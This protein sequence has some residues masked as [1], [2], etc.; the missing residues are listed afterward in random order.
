MFKKI[1]LIVS[2]LTL[3]VLLGISLYASKDELINPT[4][5]IAHEW[6]TFT[7]V[8]GP[9]GK[10]ADWLPLSG[11]SDLPCFVDYFETRLFKGLGGPVAAQPTPAQLAIT[12][13]S[14]SS[15]LAA[16][17]QL[18]GPIRME[19]PVIYFYSPRPEKVD[20]RVDFP[21]GFI[22][23]WYPEANV[24]QIAIQTGNLK[25]TSTGASIAW[26]NVEILSRDSSAAF[27]KG[28]SPSHYYA[29]RAT[30]ANPVRVNGKNEKFL[31]YR[32]VGGFAVPIKVSVTEA[33]KIHIKHLT[34]KPSVILFESRS[35]K[36][37]YTVVDTNK[38]DAVLDTPPLTGSFDALRREL[39]SVLVGQGL[40]PREASAMVDTW[41][42]S[43]F[44]EGTRVFYIVP[45][46]MVDA[47]LPLQIEPKPAQVARV[48]VGRVEVFTPT[49]IEA[50]E[51]AIATNDTSVIATYGRFLGPIADRIPQS[52]RVNSVLDAAF[53]KY[54]NDA[55]SC[56]N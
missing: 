34:G 14:P 1:A 10:V 8:A 53:K 15:Y 27:P 24:N 40:Y 37:G 31:F 47:I 26:K 38:D 20:V 25:K 45:T 39:E 36:L 13:K 29:A 9:D 18:L 32:G 49:T 22:T 4:Q 35:G 50:V 12:P 55:A 2:I 42:D 56:A 16:R 44:E 52:K 3:T 28:S 21:K 51:K 48:F 54:L 7:S 19:T 6:G 46:A 23:E 30:N 41:R 11:P 33:G 43:W 5:L 17:G